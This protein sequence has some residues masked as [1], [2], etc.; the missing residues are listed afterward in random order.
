MVM[1]PVRGKDGKMLVFESEE[2]A[3][4]YATGH[5]VNEAI[6]VKVDDPNK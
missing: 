5:C 4:S 6:V 1:E 2:D 3:E